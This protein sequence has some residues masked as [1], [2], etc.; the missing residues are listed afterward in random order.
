[1]SAKKDKPIEFLYLTQEEVKT[2]GGADMKMV[3]DA[4]EEVLKLHALNKVNVPPKT[5]L[6][7]GEKTRGR[8]NSMPA[9]VGGDM[10]VCGI[11]WIASFP[12]NPQK[13]GI[14]RATG[15]IILTDSWKGVPLAIMDGTLISAMRTGAVTGVAAKYMAR[16]D[17][18]TVAMIGCGVQARTQLSALK[19][20]LPGIKTVK[21]YDPNMATAERYAKDMITQFG[22]N[23]KA[24]ETAKEAVTGADIIV[25]VTVADEPIVKN[26]WVKEGSFFCHVGSYQ[27][28]EYEV[29]LNSQKRFVDDWEQVEHRGT[30]VLAK[31]YKEGKLKK[32]DLTGTIGDAIIGKIKGRD[33]DKQRIFCEPIGMG[34]EDV[35]VGFRV[36]KKS[37]QKKLGQKLRLWTKPELS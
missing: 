15:L 11:K 18:E 14:P 19:T 28:E 24:T 33:N 29:V 35:A 36:Y 5:V 2:A 31:M 34:S 12:A 32:E 4:V 30:S 7:L 23:A 21:G 13:Y 16:K 20:V 10:D 22:I 17:S 26:A 8:I 3:V 9:Y 27:E 6:D 25:T 37:L 1:M